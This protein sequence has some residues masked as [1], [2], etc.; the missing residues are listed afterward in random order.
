MHIKQFILLCIYTFAPPFYMMCCTYLLQTYGGQTDFMISDLIPVFWGTIWIPALLSLS[1]NFFI[2]RQKRKHLQ[3][4]EKL[5]DYP[6]LFILIYSLYF[7]ILGQTSWGIDCLYSALSGIL[8]VLF[9]LFFRNTTYRCVEYLPIVEKFYLYTVAFL[10]PIIILM[11]TDILSL[12]EETP[13]HMAILLSPISYVGGISVF[14]SACMLLKLFCLKN[15][16]SLRK[17]C[18][19]LKQTIIWLLIGDNLATLYIIPYIGNRLFVVGLMMSIILYFIESI[20][21][22]IRLH[23]RKKKK[24]N[25]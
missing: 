12:I 9:I 1:L 5:K 7:F 10:F 21:E 8:L 22:I 11:T 16:I 18:F 6:L 4:N 14:I 25:T 19:T 24:I 20:Y 15:N 13:W 17:H 23:Q 3:Q 2:R